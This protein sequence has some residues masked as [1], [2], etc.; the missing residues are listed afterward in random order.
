MAEQSNVARLS[1]VSKA[2]ANRGLNMG[3]HETLT[4]YARQT[5]A[6]NDCDFDMAVRF[7]RDEL[8]EVSRETGLSTEVIE[9][10]CRAP[11]EATTKEPV[12]LSGWYEHTDGTWGRYGWHAGRLTHQ[13]TVAA[14]APRPTEAERIARDTADYEA[15]MAQRAEVL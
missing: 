15:T 12:T 4:T 2:L 1:G 3:I 8:G 7:M 13:E 11:R 5:A 14:D 6:D 10:W 9:D